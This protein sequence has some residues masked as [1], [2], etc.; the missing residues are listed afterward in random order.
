MTQNRKLGEVEN[1]CTSHNFS[2][3]A[4]FLSKIIKIVGN[5]TKF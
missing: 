2:L 4:L 1:E 3:F 5:L